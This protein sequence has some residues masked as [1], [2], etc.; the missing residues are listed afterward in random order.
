MSQE[1]VPAQVSSPTTSSAPETLS[2]SVAHNAIDTMPIPMICLNSKLENVYF[3]AAFAAYVEFDSASVDQD[4]LRATNIMP[5]L[6]PYGLCSTETLQKFIGIALEEGHYQHPWTLT[7]F[8]GKNISAHMSLVANPEA[9]ENCVN[10]FF[11]HMVDGAKIA[12][13]QEAEASAHLDYI[14]DQANSTRHPALHA[15][16]EVDRDMLEGL[17][18]IMHIWSKDL[19]LV[20]CSTEATSAFGVAD[21]DEF[22]Q[23]FFTLCPATQMGRNSGELMR[24]Y[25]Q[26]TFEEGFCK[27]KWLHQDVNGKIF[28]CEVTLCR[29]T[30]LDEECVL[31][32]TQ[33][34]SRMSGHA[35]D[36]AKVHESTRAMLDAAPIA[37]TMWDTSFILRDANMEC[38]RLFGF[39]TPSDFMKNFRRIIPKTQES[40]ESSLTVVRRALDTAFT[41]GYCRGNFSLY[42][43]HDRKAIP[44]EITLVRLSVWNEDVVVAYVRDLRD[45]KAL[46]EKMQSAEER[47]QKIFDITPLGINV[48]DKTYKTIECN[49]AIVKMYGFKDKK[50]YMTTGYKTIPRVQPDGTPT[51]SIAQKMVD[52]AFETGYANVEWLTFDLQG[53]PIP[54][55]VVF[56]RAYVQKQEVVI[57]YS[58]DLRD[59]KAKLAE[60]QAAEQELR[61]ARDIAEQNTQAKTQFL[62]N[63][64][65]EIRTPLNCVLGLLHVLNTTPLQP[66]QKNYVNKSIE[67]ADKLLE[68]V[69]NILDF[70]QIDTGTLEMSTVPFTLSDIINE[71]KLVYEPQ[72]TAKKLL[73]NCFIDETCDRTLYGDAARLKQVIFH[74][75][76][77]AVKF[78]DSG[79]ITF[80]VSCTEQQGDE[81]KYIFSVE[82][83]GI[84]MTKAESTLIFSAFSQADSSITRNYEGSGLGLAIAKR[85]VKLMHG[86]M[87]VKSQK[88]KGS[89][90]FFTALFS[91][92]EINALEAS[93][94]A[95]TQ[96][97]EQ[98]TIPEQTPA[99]IA[100]Q[101]YP[102]KASLGKI[103]LAEDNDINQLI[104]VELLKNKGYTIDVAFNGKE[105]IEMI[106]EDEYD[107]VF[108]D[109]QMPVMD[110]LTAT[111]KIRAMSEFA[112]LPIVAMSAHAMR[113]DIELCLQYGM[114]DHLSK[115]VN[116]ELLYKA[117]EKWVRGS[118]T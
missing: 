32:Y 71:V 46:I 15:E 98:P 54:V 18:L 60:I 102:P 93:P 78:T 84:G 19:E 75:L 66:S 6:Q 8:T 97:N 49:E 86:D 115:P 5:E 52:K 63:M 34:L 76:N 16:H 99:H 67:A 1:S 12:A 3:N 118:N 73:F 70:S 7:T 110:G 27:F 83:S 14:I 44:L 61:T 72:T 88:E 41:E 26:K 82:D 85:I 87:W 39:E 51:L 90:F 107:L 37:I 59:M 9:G 17:P 92:S 100:S 47:I 108:M 36:F 45:V 40:G 95:I 25:L 28:P 55:E 74:I 29:I 21:R 13:S 57:A 20:D 106:L 30:H 43:A 81:I 77:N 113:G 68:L 42:H 23:K 33:D 111:T 116:P 22:E 53:S 109:I 4:S 117:V 105:A 101:P 24:E 96:D 62:G 65:H 112:H 56:K 114:N 69:N 38:A 80:N 10:C 31:G 91:R 35:H 89:T 79:F 48:W 58:R 2:S 11:L 94:C 103:L 104:I 50:A 64:S